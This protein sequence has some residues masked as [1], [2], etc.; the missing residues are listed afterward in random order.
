M[1]RLVNNYVDKFSFRLQMQP[2]PQI[3]SSYAL[4]KT[5]KPD[6]DN[7]FQVRPIVNQ[8]NTKCTNLHKKLFMPLF[9]KLPTGFGISSRKTFATVGDY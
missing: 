3:K 9:E 4:F 1:L 7:N 8:I 2:I 5:H 6:F